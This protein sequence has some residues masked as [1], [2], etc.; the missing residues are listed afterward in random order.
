MEKPERLLSAAEQVA[1]LKGK[2]VRFTIM[3]E[4]AAQEYLTYNN[5]YFNLTAYRKNYQKHPG[6]AKMGQYVRLEF[7]YLVDLSEIDRLLRYEILQLSLD[8]EHHARLALLRFLEQQQVEPYEIVASYM[9]SLSVQDRHILQGEIARNRGNVY[10]GD[11]V[12]KYDGHYPVWVFLELISFGRL[13]SFYRY[14]GERFMSPTMRSDYRYLQNCRVVRNAAAHSSCILNDCR[15]GSAKYY[16]SGE[17]AHELARIKELSKSARKARMSNARLQQLTVLLFMHRYRVSSRRERYEAAQRLHALKT[18]M[19]LHADYYAD[20][21]LLAST[22]D[23]MKI[24]ID[25][26]SSNDVYQ[27]QH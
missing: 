18:R 22:F 19:D 6:G 14:C 7:A 23:F 27:I 17:F 4:E 9:E 3:D 21:P 10:C 12:A 16:P 5:N 8:V 15:G 13:L 26:W 24:V 11:L 1:Y 20:N 25:S 2:G